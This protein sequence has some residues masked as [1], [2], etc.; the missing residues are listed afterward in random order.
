[1]N[2]LADVSAHAATR[3]LSL[4]HPTDFSATSTLALA[5]SV[6]LSLRLGGRLTLLHIRREEDA[7][8]TRNGLAPIADLLARWGRLGVHEKFADLKS[9]CGID[10]RCLDVPARSISVGLHEHFEAQPVD[11]AV[12]ATTPHSGLNYW[13][14]GSISRRA[15]REAEAMILFIREGQRGLIDPKTGAITARRVL[16]PLDGRMPIAPAL[17]RAARL[18]DALALPLE[19][20]FLHIGDAAPP[21]TPKDIPLT[22]AHGPVVETILHCAQTWRADLIVMPTPGRRGL[23]TRFRNSVSAAIL[24]DG[25]WPVLSVPAL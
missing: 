17:A 1:M 16:I 14:A 12:L 9:K 7:G 19:K 22:L 24:D 20:R 8:P 3:G 10:A 23:L 21:D 2:A 4:L 25:R 18:L 15:L 13:F 6:A 5:H 11:L